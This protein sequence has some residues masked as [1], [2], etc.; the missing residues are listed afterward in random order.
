MKASMLGFPLASLSS[1]CGTSLSV[2][3]HSAAQQISIIR[4]LHEKKKKKN[5][6]DRIIQHT[7]SDFKQK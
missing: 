7:A 1:P 2:P 5:Q 4:A 6:D 3:L